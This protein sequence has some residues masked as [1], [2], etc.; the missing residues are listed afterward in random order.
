MKVSKKPKKVKVFNDLHLEPLET[1]TKEVEVLKFHSKNSPSEKMYAINTPAGLDKDT[2]KSLEMMG[3]DVVDDKDS[4]IK[5]RSH[6]T[7]YIGE[8]VFHVP[9]PDIV[10]HVEGYHDNGFYDSAV[11]YSYV[12]PNVPRLGDLESKKNYVNNIL[13]KRLVHPG[14]NRAISTMLFYSQDGYS[15]SLLNILADTNNTNT[16]APS[17][18]LDKISAG[19]IEEISLNA[20]WFNI[21][22]EF[23]LNSDNTTLEDSLDDD[24]FVEKVKKHYSNLTYESNEHTASL[25][26]AIFNRKS[27]LCLKDLKTI[28]ARDAM[29]SLSVKALKNYTEIF[30]AKNKKKK[31]SDAHRDFTS[32]VLVPLVNIDRN[33][34]KAIEIWVKR[35]EEKDVKK[36]D[37]ITSSNLAEYLSIAYANN[38]VKANSVYNSDSSGKYKGLLQKVLSL[39]TSELAS[40]LSYERSKILIITD[41]LNALG[42]EF[43]TKEM[44]LSHLH[45]LFAS[46]MRVETPL[47]G[48]DNV[49]RK[50]FLL[51]ALEL[52]EDT[53][54]GKEKALQYYFEANTQFVKIG[55][56]VSA[57]EKENIFDGAD[58]V[59]LDLV[60]SIFGKE[61]VS[62]Q[63]SRYP[64]ISPSVETAIELNKQGF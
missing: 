46:F 53:V 54:K 15:V 14:S 3:I 52:S 27:P 30:N 63:E 13:T 58:D 12:I 37:V 41:I 22:N 32:T 39:N 48:R 40:E 62:V 19:K 16:F 28:K 18:Y 20:A 64:N 7:N 57:L 31:K 24:T 55:I 26:E 38:V 51:K 8:H 2:L 10:K 56:S 5:K 17:W 21:L 6:T 1:H 9:S 33:P 59:P 50:S 60:L 45:I 34:S 42:T 35:L 23:I 36:E 44:K 43:V 29:K 61:V 11:W 47:I 49:W 4:I 25:A